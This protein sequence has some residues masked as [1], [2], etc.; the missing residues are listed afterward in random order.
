MEAN[1]NNSWLIFEYILYKDIFLPIFINQNT[2]LVSHFRIYEM[3]FGFM[4]F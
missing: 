2:F 4:K 1:K 3:D